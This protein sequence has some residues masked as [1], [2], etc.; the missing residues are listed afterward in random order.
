MRKAAETP[1][2]FCSRKKGAVQVKE[3]VHF[4]HLG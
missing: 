1:L 4:G 3:V 2:L